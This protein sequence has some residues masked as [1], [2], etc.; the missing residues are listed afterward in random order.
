MK[1]R[2]LLIFEESIKSKATRSNYTDHLNRFLQFTR[3]KDY[4]SLLKLDSDQLQT[5]LE[6]YVMHLKKTVSPNSVPIYMTGIKHFFIMN[7][8]RIFWEMNQISQGL[9][10]H[11]TVEWDM[12]VRFIQIHDNSIGID[13]EVE[14]SREYLEHLSGKWVSVIYEVTNILKKHGVTFGIWHKQAKNMLTKF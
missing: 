6:D 5:I 9:M 8:V 12:H 1:Q 3:L 14:T 2:S 7:R 10:K 4:D 11:L 13:V